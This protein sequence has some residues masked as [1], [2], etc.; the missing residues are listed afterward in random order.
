MSS[1]CKNQRKKKKEALWPTPKQTYFPIKKLMVFGEK[2]LT[3]HIF[4]FK[5]CFGVRGSRKGK[6]CNYFFIGFDRL[7]PKAKLKN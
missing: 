2:F 7:L 3:Q 6:S 5:T 1:F 4:H